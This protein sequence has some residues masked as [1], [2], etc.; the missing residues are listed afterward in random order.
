MRTWRGS[1]RFPNV[2]EPILNDPCSRSSTQR[3]NRLRRQV[4]HRAD[5]LASMV[6]QSRLAAGGDVLR[7]P[8]STSVF[9]RMT[10]REIR[11][12]GW[13]RFTPGALAHGLRA[14]S[15]EPVP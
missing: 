4:P 11:A 10:C 9:N 7:E 2:P 8:A 15:R 12:L 5:T 1:T 13:F 3:F 6:P 14:G